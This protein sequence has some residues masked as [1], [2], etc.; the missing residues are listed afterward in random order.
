MVNKES[1]HRSYFVPGVCL[2]FRSLH[3]YLEIRMDGVSCVASG[4]RVNV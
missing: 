3:A 4:K 2:F 1:R